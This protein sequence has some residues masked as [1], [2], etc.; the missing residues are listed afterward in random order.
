MVKIRA[1][2]GQEAFPS[3]CVSS[4]SLSL[5]KKSLDAETDKQKIQSV[6]SSWKPFLRCWLLTFKIRSLRCHWFSMEAISPGT[7]WIGQREASGPPGLKT[8]R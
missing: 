7:G 5:Q 6:L 4:I 1:C 8:K 2:V 3:L